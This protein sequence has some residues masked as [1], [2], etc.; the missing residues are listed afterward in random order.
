MLPESTSA[1]SVRLRRTK[2]AR[3]LFAGTCIP[4]R[5]DKHHRDAHVPHTTHSTPCDHDKA[6]NTKSQKNTTGYTRWTNMHAEKAEKCREG[7]SPRRDGFE[8]GTA[9]AK[10]GTCEPTNPNTHLTRPLHEERAD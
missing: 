5:D 3:T 10:D 8:R 6:R 2:A 1:R 4:T 7:R 9:R